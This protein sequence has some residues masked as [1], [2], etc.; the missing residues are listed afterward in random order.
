MNKKRLLKKEKYE[1]EFARALNNIRVANDGFF[2][3]LSRLSS[4]YSVKG[5]ETHNCLH[6]YG[7]LGRL[8]E[9]NA[10]SSSKCN[11]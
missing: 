11:H 6:E 3:F 10:K 9:G 1:T 7:G 4:K 8:S 2:V 5:N